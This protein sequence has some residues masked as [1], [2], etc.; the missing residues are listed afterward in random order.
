MSQNIILPGAEPF[1]FSGGRIGCLL[2]HG[3]TGTPKEMRL[4]GDH[5]KQQGHTVLGIRLA[6]HAT[7][8][9]D[10]ARTRWWDWLASVED[11][12]NLL[13]GCT[14]EQ[15]LMGLSL[16]GVLSL[17]SAT[18]YPVRG[19]VAMST[20]FGLPNDPRIHFMNI[21]TMLQPKMKK[22]EDV[23]FNKEAKATHV[24]LPFTP[25]RA[26]MEVVK[27]IKELQRVLPDVKVPTLLVQSRLDSVVPAGSLD[28]IYANIGS[29][30]KTSL[31]V[32]NSG[33]VIT[34]EPDRQQVFDAA[35]NFISRLS[36]P[37]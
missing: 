9:Q 4:M 10:L 27:A 25:S 36:N 12:L 18:R 1:S 13:K 34:E 17:L 19:V 22:G 2:V 16:G 21:L 29:A 26:M 33:H 23:F 3:F 14:E 15:Y 11:G 37:A 20:P 31:W 32:E 35:A 6:G 24:A 5:L 8:W 30:D 7:T 28:G